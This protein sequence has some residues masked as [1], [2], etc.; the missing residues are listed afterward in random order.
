MTHKYPLDRLFLIPVVCLLLVVGSC[1][2]DP[3][4]PAVATPKTLGFYETIQNNYRILLMSVSQVGTQATP[5]KL[6]FDTGSGGLVIDANGILPASMITSTGF[7]FTGDSTV[8]NGITITNQTNTVVYGDDNNTQ[9]TVYGNLAYANVTVGDANGNVVVKH[10]PFFLYYKGVNSKGAQVAPHSF[11]VLGVSSEYDI[12]FPNGS[13]I[14]SPFT[15]YDPGNGLKR[16]FRMAKLGTSNFSTSGT[17][18]PALTVGLTDKDLNSGFNMTQ[19]LN[20]PNEGYIPIIPGSI[21][22][23]NQNIP[24]EMLFDT[25]TSPYSIIEFTGAPASQISILPA[26]SNVTITT[27]TG[28]NYDYLTGA[29]QNQTLVE[30]PAAS[31]TYLSVFGLDFFIENEYM[32]NF[33]DHEVGVK[34]N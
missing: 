21:G 31:G 30:N 11:D 7:S 29:S 34:T 5:Y 15:Y 20:I 19:L 12:F 28:F 17:Y 4:T 13:Y 24:A 27:S 1:K 10:L 26:N 14:T 32:L 22:L 23:I 18:V 2:K 3:H 6:I 8:V 33:D 25:G 9:T 16:G